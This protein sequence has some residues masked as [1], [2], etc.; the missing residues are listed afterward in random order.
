MVSWIHQSNS[1][2]IPFSQGVYSLNFYAGNFANTTSLVQTNNYTIDTTAPTVSANL[3]SGVYSSP[4][5]VTLTASDNLDPNPVIYYSID[6]GNTGFISL[7]V[8]QFHLVR[9]CIV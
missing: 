1:V 8:L 3:G 5:S 6:D 9:V 2:T 7:I 4:Q